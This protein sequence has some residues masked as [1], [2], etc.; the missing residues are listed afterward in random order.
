M[1]ENAIDHAED[2]GR[3]RDAEND[4]KQGDDR[5]SGTGAQHAQ[6][7]ANVLQ[8]CVHRLIPVQRNAEQHRKAY[9]RLDMK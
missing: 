5:E 8:D 7:V 2:G 9:R 1:K 4:G 3:A 6:P